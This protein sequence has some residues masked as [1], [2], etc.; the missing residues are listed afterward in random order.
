[1]SLLPSKIVSSIISN[2]IGG[3]MK[4]RLSMVVAA[5]VALGLSLALTSCG[6]KS[7]TVTFDLNGGEG[8]APSSMS[9]DKDSTVTLTDYA[10]TDYTK[11]GYTAL[12]WNTAT[13]S[14]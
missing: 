6:T 9:V 4:R 8:T 12:G 14:T 2:S 5:L 10:V 13:D 3:I 11:S 1:M 7:Y